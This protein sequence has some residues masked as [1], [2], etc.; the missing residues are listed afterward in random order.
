MSVKPTTESFSF[1]PWTIQS[2][3]GPILKSSDAD[4]ITL[5]LDIPAIPEMVFGSNQLKIEHTDGFGIQ[6]DAL[7]A[8]KR[9]DT[10]RDLMKVAYAEEWKKQ[11]EGSEFIKNVVKPYDW[12]YTTDYQGTLFSRGAEMI[13]SDTSERIDI[14]RLKVKEKIHFYTDL[15]LFEDELGDNGTAMLSVKIR[16]MPS[17]FFALLRFFLRVDDVLIRI[18]DTRLYHEA[19]WD[20]ILR[21]YSSKE[22]KMSL[23]QNPLADPSILAEQ[24]DVKLEQFD[25]LLFPEGSSQDGVIAGR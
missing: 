11:R 13:V 17:S 8:L 9:V 21:E 10:K 4:R 25:K 6:F 15:L 22:K 19:G 18:N 20:H 3:K 23:L 7:D 2:S 16:V 1:G 12:T 5:E 14:E 24:L